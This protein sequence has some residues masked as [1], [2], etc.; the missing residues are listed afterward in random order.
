ME[1]GILEHNGNMY[2]KD[3]TTQEKEQAMANQ[4]DSAGNEEKEYVLQTS[5]SITELFK[6][7]APA[8]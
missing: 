6:V 5:K 7:Q 8:K 3:Q 1:E 2:P 4:E